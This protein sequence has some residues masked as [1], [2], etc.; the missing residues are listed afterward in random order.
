MFRENVISGFRRRSFKGA[1]LL[2]PILCPSSLAER[3]EKTACGL[4]FGMS[5]ERGKELEEPED[6][7][8]D[9]REEKGGFAKLGGR[10]GK[11]W[12]G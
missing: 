1:F 3:A 7:E 5:G 8:T 12:E 10:R 4:I 2:V 11:E 6:Q 9:N